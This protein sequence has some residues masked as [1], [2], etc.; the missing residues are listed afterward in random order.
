MT[1]VRIGIIGGGPGGICMIECQVA[2]I[3]RQLQRFTSQGVAWIEPRR[4][5]RPMS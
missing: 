3:T 5:R 4:W 1:R 2:Y